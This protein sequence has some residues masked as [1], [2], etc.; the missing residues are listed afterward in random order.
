MDVPRVLP[1][2]TPEDTDYCPCLASTDPQA[3]DLVYLGNSEV[4]NV[5]VGV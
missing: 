5:L 1:I 3:Q 4:S 2:P